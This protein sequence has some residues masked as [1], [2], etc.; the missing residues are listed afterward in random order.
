[1]ASQSCSTRRQGRYWMATISYQSQWTPTLPDGV[2]FL[3]GQLEEGE[4]GF[5]HYQLF[6]ITEQKASSSRCKVLFDTPTGHYELTRS[7]AAEKYVWKEE[8][9][10]GEQFEFGARPLRRNTKTDWE[11]VWKCATEGKLLELPSSVRVQHYRTL[12]RIATDYLRPAPMVRTA[13]VYWGPTGTGKSRRAWE[14][15]GIGAYPKDPRTKFWCG[16]Q[17]QEYVVADEFRGTIDIAN[18]LRWLDRY[19]VIV[20]IKGGAVVLQA[21]RFWFTSNVNPI[22]WYPDLD[23]ATRDALMRR[24]E[25]I[26]ME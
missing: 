20:E 21:K 5:K 24:L 10:V 8:T 23:S 6:F 14:E 12:Q 22:Y 7:E 3:R 4:G 13:V 17:G 11:E 25:V 2:A 16:Y 19:P 1:M 15:A 18:L 9:R 26:E